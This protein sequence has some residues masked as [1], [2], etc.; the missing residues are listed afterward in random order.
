MIINEGIEGNGNISGLLKN[1]VFILSTLIRSPQQFIHNETE[2][3][4]ST[5]IP[6]V[7]FPEFVEVI[8]FETSKI[9]LL[10]KTFCLMMLY[11]VDF[12]DWVNLSLDGFI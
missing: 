5:M 2:T 10:E 7:L 3:V 6:K 12:P 4:D 11:S 8:Q 9:D 1:Q